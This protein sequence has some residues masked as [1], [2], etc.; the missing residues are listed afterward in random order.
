MELHDPILKHISKG[1]RDSF[2]T[3]SEEPSVFDRVERRLSV[4][5]PKEDPPNVIDGGLCKSAPPNGEGWDKTLAVFLAHLACSSSGPHVA[6]GL[7]RNGR[8]ESTRAQVVTI[9]EKLRNGQS[10][11]SGWPRVY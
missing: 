7:L 3:D 9:A 5:A 4:F 10:D 2:G 11:P 8:I 1:S 6:R